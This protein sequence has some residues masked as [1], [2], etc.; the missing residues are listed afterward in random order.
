[1]V[2]TY[3]LGPSDLAMLEVAVTAM[4]R[5]EQCRE[6]IDEHG[7]VVKTRLG[8]LRTNP[9]V[10]EERAQN[11]VARRALVA[12]G[13]DGGAIADPRPGRRR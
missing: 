5:A 3:T 11:E 13:V 4:R 7:V 1:M 12:L 6:A 9:A 8:E 10:L 2:S